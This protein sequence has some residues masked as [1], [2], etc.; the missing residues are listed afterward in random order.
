[1]IIKKRFVRVPLYVTVEQRVNPL[2]KDL[3]LCELTEFLITRN[4]LWSENV[5]LDNHLLIFC[6]KG[7]GIIQI[8]NDLVPF[9]QNQYCIIPQGFIFKI[10]VVR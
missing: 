7:N 10:T 9:S 3:Y 5:I 8:A 2:T 1:M 4:T 6:T